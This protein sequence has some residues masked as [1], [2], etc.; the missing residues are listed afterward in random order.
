[1]SSLLFLLSV[2]NS[3]KILS[4]TLLQ[5]LSQFKALEIY[6]RTRKTN[7]NSLYLQ[8]VS[9]VG[10][11]NIE[12]SHLYGKFTIY[13]S[14]NEG[15]PVFGNEKTPMSQF[16]PCPTVPRFP[17]PYFSSHMRNMLASLVGVHP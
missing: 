12:T 11:Y 1:M 6:L 4:Y 17:L 10:V 8:F 15:H 7:F 2:L 5:K 9:K 3:Q 16:V 13:E 14:F